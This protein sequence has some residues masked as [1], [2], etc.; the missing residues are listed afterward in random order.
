MGLYNP[1]TKARTIFVVYKWYDFSCQLGDYILPIPPFRGTRNN[2]YTTYHPLQELEKSIERSSGFVWT[3]SAAGPA[4]HG[5]NGEV[6]SLPT[7]PWDQFRHIYLL[8]Y[9]KKS[10]KKSR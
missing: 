4:G 8:I 2:Q 7:N 5:P 9:H 1:Q 6:E 10:S 3:S